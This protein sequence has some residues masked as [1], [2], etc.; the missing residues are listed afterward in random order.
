LLFKKNILIVD[1]DAS[2]FRFA[3][4]AQLRSGFYPDHCELKGWPSSFRL[5]K[6]LNIFIVFYD[7]SFVN[8]NLI[9]RRNL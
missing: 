1:C 8:K 2:D 5:F 3:D 7:T 4:K 9:A 6:R